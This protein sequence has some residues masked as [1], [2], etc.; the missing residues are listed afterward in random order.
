MCNGLGGSGQAALT[1][2]G[3][4]RRLSVFVAA[5]TTT[6]VPGVVAAPARADNP[7]DQF[8]QSQLS[9]SNR[10]PGSPTSWLQEGY[11][12]CRNLTAKVAAGYMLADADWYEVE[13]LSVRPGW[14]EDSAAGVVGDAETYLC[15]QLGGY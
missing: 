12:V 8:V 4:R 11:Q 14:D 15:P 2:T 13:R 10:P 1:V 7:E 9:Y 5:L 3:I 6:L